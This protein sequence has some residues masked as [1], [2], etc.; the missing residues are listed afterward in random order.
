VDFEWRGFVFGNFSVL[1]WN[2]LNGIQQGG[3]CMKI[4]VFFQSCWYR[5]L[6]AYNIF[7]GLQFKVAIEGSSR[8]AATYFCV[9]QDIDVTLQRVS[10]VSYFN[11][12]PKAYTRILDEHKKPRQMIEHHTDFIDGEY[13]RSFVKDMDNYQKKLW[14]EIMLLRQSLKRGLHPTRS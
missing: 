6:H 2:P 10:N 14:P 8:V 1:I 9:D 7:S 12:L 3:L 13:T 4:G 5:P 11:S